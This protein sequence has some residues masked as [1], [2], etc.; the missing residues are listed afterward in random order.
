MKTAKFRALLAL[1]KKRLGDTFVSGCDYTVGIKTTKLY[2]FC[3]L[4]L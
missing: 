4:N 3:V 2:F 1:Y